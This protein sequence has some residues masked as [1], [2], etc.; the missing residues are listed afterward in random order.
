MRSYSSFIADKSKCGGLDGF[1]PIWMPDCLFDFQEA[2][3][4]WSIRKGRSALF[5]DCGLGKTIQQL[6]WAENVVRKT[7]KPVLVLTPL[8]VGPQ[9]VLEA[10]KF[11]IESVR[12]R[13]GRLPSG[14]R[15]VVTNYQQLHHFNRSD[16]AGVVCDESSI[17]KNFKGSTKEAVTEF[18]RLIPYRLLCTATAAP[19]DYD[20]LGTSSEALGEL[21]YQDMIT[22]FFKQEQKGGCHGWARSK[23]RIRGHAEKGFWQWVC[24]WARACRKPSDIGFDDGRFILPELVVNVSEVKALRAA[25][26]RL[27][28]VP[29]ETLDEQRE[30]Q[31][32]TLPE[33]C[34]RV[35]ELVAKHDCSVVWC[36]LNDEG[37]YL[38]K[39]IKGSKQI[40]GSD[41]DES[42][43]ETF[44]AFASGELKRLVIKPKIGAWGLNWQHCAHQTFFP[45]HSFEQYYQGVRRCWRF[46]QN[47]KVHVDIVSTEG[48]DRVLNNL[49]RKS[50]A[51]DRMFENLVANMNESI[52]ISAGKYGDKKE[53]VPTWLA[54]T[55]I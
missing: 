51:C 48:G 16:F 37:D 6:V 36:F 45:S 13:D 26:G 24:S 28:D 43:E 31:R 9:T 27:F 15:I 29:A 22:K 11:G 14:S 7:N 32:R 54:S 40:S 19:N 35:A 55:R 25:E 50:D 5:E 33:R 52:R 44:A 42:K 38:E 53:S 23:Y 3:T 4:E 2:M 1:D 18:C 12:S 39:I 47:R 30:E 21:G 10:E 17:L 41:S 49:N 34:Q 46:G 20:E 8:A